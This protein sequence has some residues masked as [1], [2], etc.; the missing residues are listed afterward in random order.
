MEHA[1][2]WV[3]SVSNYNA[4][5]AHCKDGQVEDRLQH[6]F[7]TEYKHVFSTFKF[8]TFLAIFITVTWTLT[9]CQNNFKAM[10]QVD[11]CNNGTS[12]ELLWYFYN[13]GWDSRFNK[14]ST[15]KQQNKIY[16]TENGSNFEV[17]LE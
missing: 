16:I 7:R 12:L 5:V 3:Q 8:N 15:I 17:N 9:E 6:F 10:F 4:K 14:I 2:F 13:Y 11:N 1:I